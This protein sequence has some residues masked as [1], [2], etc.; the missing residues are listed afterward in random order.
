[1]FPLKLP[2]GK[3]FSTCQPVSTQPRVPRFLSR[4]VSLKL[5]VSFNVQRR[6]IAGPKRYRFHLGKFHHDL[7]VTEPWNH[8]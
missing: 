4:F 1:M 8:G 3:V 7:T 2:V 6:Y 5:G